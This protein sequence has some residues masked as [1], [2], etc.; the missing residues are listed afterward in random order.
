M[1]L[2]GDSE[3]LCGIDTVVIGGVATAPIFPIHL[4]RLSKNGVRTLR[5]DRGGISLF[6]SVR[7]D[8]WTFRLQ[9]SLPR[10]VHGDNFSTIPLDRLSYELPF[11]IE[12]ARCRFPELDHI[13]LEELPVRRVDIAFDLAVEATPRLIQALRDCYLSNRNMPGF[14]Y[15]GKKTTSFYSKDTRG[16]RPPSYRSLIGYGKRYLESGQRGLRLESRFHTSYIS[17]KH[18]KDF[19]LLKLAERCHE[20]LVAGWKY[21]DELFELLAPQTDQSLASA[22]RGAPE[23]QRDFLVSFGFL[24]REVPLDDLRPI[25][26]PGGKIDT[27]CLKK[28]GIGF[29]DASFP[30]L[31]MFAEIR[32]EWSLRFSCPYQKDVS[33]SAREECKQSSDCFIEQLNGR[34]AECTGDQNQL[35][36]RN[37]SVTSFDLPDRHRMP[38]ELCRELTLRNALVTTE[39]RDRLSEAMLFLKK[40][41]TTMLARHYRRE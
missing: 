27:R 11:F 9:C 23:K 30:E 21:I 40:R 19:T 32:R 31:K 38:T 29:G 4:L 6:V 20:L 14:L 24:S 8:R 2:G 26:F 22:V 41:L 1:E 16:K 39:P 37:S 34:Y 25:F 3:V 28:Y 33:R 15:A 17:K 35:D 7:N 36:D 10:L 18:G 5:R 13:P 12:E